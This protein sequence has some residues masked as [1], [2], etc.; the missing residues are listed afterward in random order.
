MKE[1]QKS[2][3]KGVLAGMASPV[4]VVVALDGEG[5]SSNDGGFPRDEYNS[6]YA[7]RRAILSALGLDTQAEV[8]EG[9]HEFRL[10]PVRAPAPSLDLAKLVHDAGLVDYLSTVWARWEALGELRS[11]DFFHSSGLASTVGAAQ[12]TPALVPANHTFRDGL[13]LPGTSVHSQ[14]CYYHIDRIT[15]IFSGLA[16]ALR[17]DLAVVAAAADAIPFGPAEADSKPLPP[18]VYALVTHPG[19]HATAVTVG[20]FCYVNSAAVLA[21]MLQAKWAHESGGGS[22]TAPCRIAI[23]DVGTPNK[24]TDAHPSATNSLRP[25]SVRPAWHAPALLRLAMLQHRASL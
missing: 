10:F 5:G 3:S 24:Q 17:W 23:V 20:G 25:A 21:R 2:S 7:R 16:D 6:P 8:R 13:Q 22:E 15:P 19:H 9:N 11:P 18:P 1:H 12:T 14:A 4:L